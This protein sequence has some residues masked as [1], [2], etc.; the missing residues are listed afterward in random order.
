MGKYQVG[1]FTGGTFRPLSIKLAGR[2]PSAAT[3][4][5]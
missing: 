3:I 4:A 2:A 1:L 5:F